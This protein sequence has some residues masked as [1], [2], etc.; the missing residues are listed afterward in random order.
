MMS[1]PT[2]F[3]KVLVAAC[4]LFLQF[5][6]LGA[7]ART[8]TSTSNDASAIGTLPYWLLNASDGDVIDCSL[9]AGQ[10]I[11]LNSSL[12]AITKNYTIN[13]AGI[14]IDGASSYQAFQ[15]VS[16]TVVI[17]DIVVQ[18][19]ISKGGDGGSGTSGGGGAVGGGGALYIH[20]GS[21][22]TLTVSSLID[23]IAQGGNGGAASNN[24]QAGAGGGG[25]FGGGNGGSCLTSLTSGG[26]GGGYSNGG[27]GGG[28]SSVNGSSGV[29]FGGGGGGGGLNG[30]GGGNGGNASPNGAFIGGAQAQGDGGGGAGDSQNGFSATRGG[31]GSDMPGN[32]GNGIGIDLLFGGGGGGGGG[33][34][35]G[36]PG[37]TGIGAAGGGGGPSYLG[38]PGGILGGGGGGGLGI[39]GGA[40]TA[41]GP[42][43]FGAG[44]GGGL[45]GGLGGGGFGAGGGNGGS[46]PSNVGGGGGGSGLGGAIFIQKGALLTIAD[47]TQIFGNLA[48]AGVG[49][50][51]TNS[52]DPGYI[53]AGDGAAMGN[54]IFIRQGG[55]LV[56]DLSNTLSISTPIEGD[57]LSTPIDNTG[58]LT[59]RGGGV[60]QLQGINTYVGP[61][62]VEQ[63]NLNLNGSIS[64]NIFIQQNGQ[65]SGNAAIGGN[66]FNSGTLSPGNSIGTISTTNLTMSS[67]SVYR[68]EIDPANSDLI[69]ASGEALLA[70][71][72]QV[73]QNSGIYP[74][75]GEYLI[76]TTQDG[77]VGS[78]TLEVM[79]GLPGYQFSLAQ[80]QNNLYLLY[81]FTPPAPIDS[82][83]P[84]THL[85]GHQKVKEKHEQIKIYNILKWDPPKQRP[86]ALP[87]TN[88]RI[89]KVKDSNFKLIGLV[90]STSK[91]RFKQEIHQRKHQ[92]KYAITAINISLQES[93]PEY[94]TIK[95][96]KFSS[97]KF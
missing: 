21:S 59:K 65:L 29:Y 96:K 24:G 50:S 60:L 82:I 53:A 88:Y 37:G 35:S 13:G 61:T 81:H 28:D 20:G 79:Q 51:S 15:V 30:E 22:A 46:D 1:K 25:G 83:S 42:G 9:I 90:A 66:I 74:S 64:Q 77:I 87:I 86:S 19:A 3:T 33:S 55:S 84:P 10:Q 71:K 6:Q 17:N 67:T 8:V 34:D 70:G 58:S 18:N 62:I 68:V 5:I 40:Q 69:V 91:L 73:I 93:V 92:Y 36:N 57:I 52:S 89:Y 63:G 11:T 14:I 4:F 12:P 94:V 72:V 97:A 16:G 38:G 2:C 48:V 32:G 31:G 27:N 78:L 85:K 49:G 7:A 54:D 43:G 76:L 39:S 44:G 95:N 26:G 47:S 41:G 56:F 23:N 75:V 80:V 45:I